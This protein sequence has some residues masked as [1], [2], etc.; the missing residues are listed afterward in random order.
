MK[1]RTQLLVLLALFAFTTQGCISSLTGERG[2]GNIVTEERAIGSFDRMEL[3]GGFDVEL[4]KS[5]DKTLMLTT[6]NNLM[7]N[8]E[9]YVRGGTL[10]V[11]SRNVGK[12]TEMRLEINYQEIKHI[13]TSGAVDIRS[14]DIL[15]A[16][17]LSIES[18]GASELFLTLKT[19]QV[20]FDFSGA[21]E[22]ELSGSTTE[23]VFEGSGACELKAFD[24]KADRAKIEISGAGSAQV[25]VSDKLEASVSGAGNVY[26]RGNPDNIQTDISGAGNIRRD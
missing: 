26:Y 22:T 4:V 6:D 13:S 17:D 18:S 23:L 25:N 14:E 24:L 15:E 3:S 1:I 19:N 10:H 16:D 2:N 21:S 12:A 11:K 8:V 7:D 20:R 9:T 5:N